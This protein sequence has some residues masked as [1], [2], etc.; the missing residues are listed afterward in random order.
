M[1]VMRSLQQQVAMERKT[2][3]RELNEHSIKAKNA[4]RMEQW[5]LKRIKQR[6]ELAAEVRS[7]QNT[8][9]FIF[10]RENEIIIIVWTWTEYTYDIETRGGA[11]IYIYM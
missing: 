2:R 1:S 10:S 11:C 9:V 6:S 8:H 5:R 7:L 4:E 3:G